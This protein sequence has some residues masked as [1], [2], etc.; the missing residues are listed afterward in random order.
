MSWLHWRKMHHP[1][2]RLFLRLKA[3]DHKPFVG[4]LPVLSGTCGFSR[5]RHA[6]VLIRVL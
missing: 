1:H 6:A 3:T 4:A 5:W 2:R